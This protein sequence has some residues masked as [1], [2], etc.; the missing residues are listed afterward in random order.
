MFT[1]HPASRHRQTL[2]VVG[3]TSDDAVMT[4]A[5]TSPRATRSNSALRSN[6]TAHA[7]PPRVAAPE[8][9][10]RFSFVLLDRWDERADT[11]ASRCPAAAS[12]RRLVDA[13]GPDPS[14]PAGIGTANTVGMGM[15]DSDAELVATAWL[16]APSGGPARFAM[17]VR[18]DHR[19]R[20]LGSSLLD[21]GI[22]HARLLAVPCVHSDVPYTEPR[23]LSL[24]R[25]RGPV[26]PVAPADP[27]ARTLCLQLASDSDC[28][29]P[30]ATTS[31]RT[32]V[33]RP[34]VH[35]SSATLLCLCG[36]ALQPHRPHR[37]SPFGGRERDRAAIPPPGP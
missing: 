36:A 37:R 9:A 13:P 23:A 27:E 31:R 18:D 20:R 28:L 16:V 22:R 33:P 32:V 4:Q 10:A 34:P 25:S 11:F 19:F 8:G 15:V 3:P 30:A 12:V 1:E 17:A 6:P 24:L 14:H 2:E 35:R 29:H 5:T 21:I 26:R 7:L